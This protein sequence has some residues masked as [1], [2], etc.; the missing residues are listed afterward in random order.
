M[1]LANPAWRV[2]FHSGMSLSTRTRYLRLTT[3]WNA[4]LHGGDTADAWITYNATTKNVAVFWNYKANP[5][6]RISTISYLI[7]LK[8]VLPENVT[9]RFS[10]AIGQNVE[11]HIVHSWE[12]RSS[13]AIRETGGKDA[14][15]SQID[16]RFNSV[17]D[18]F[19][20]RTP[21]SICNIV[22]TEEEMDRNEEGR[23]RQLNIRG[24]YLP[25]RD[26]A[27]AVKISRGSRQGKKEYV[28]EKESNVHSFGEDAL[29]ILSG[30]RSVDPCRMADPRCGWSSGFGISMEMDTF[31]QPWT[32]N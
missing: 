20:S 28:T 21:S 3:S 23:D 17:S 29:G 12:F 4:S 16:R 9:I 19:D 5:E 32:R 6:L 26:M 10:A 24:A 14:K 8:E 13:L 11:R 31:F 30:R 27:V 2:E 7:D 22:E 15:K 25:D 1:T 18:W